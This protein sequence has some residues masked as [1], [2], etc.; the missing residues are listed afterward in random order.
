VSWLQSFSNE[1][2]TRGGLLGSNANLHY[3]LFGEIVD[4]GCNL[5]GTRVD[6][7][8]K[9]WLFLV[10]VVCLV[11]FLIFEFVCVCHYG[12]GMGW[13]GWREVAVATALFF[14]SLY[15]LLVWRTGPATGI[16]AAILMVVS[17]TKTACGTIAKLLNPYWT[18]RRSDGK[19]S[20]ESPPNSVKR[21]KLVWPDILV[22]V[23]CGV[24]SVATIVAHF[25]ECWWVHL[26]SGVIF[27]ATSV[28]ALGAIAWDCSKECSLAL[29]SLVSGLVF[30]VLTLAFNCALIVA[31]AWDNQLKIAGYFCAVNVFLLD[32]AQAFGEG[33]KEAPVQVQGGDVGA[34]AEDGDASGA[35][36]A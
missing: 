33:C 7:E 3:R 6:A 14:A 35:L 15:L 21:G 27:F 25:V 29:P 26:V 28:A 31:G 34:D 10:T 16:F 9:G 24:S 23:S 30:D 2:K 1:G 12:K 8:E 36:E 11:M 13:K 17:P 5:G 22:M 4:A 32:L 18:R 20:W 19:W